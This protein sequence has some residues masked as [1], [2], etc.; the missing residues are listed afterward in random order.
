VTPASG[1]AEHWVSDGQKLKSAWRKRMVFSITVASE[2]SS[3]KAL[4][5]VSGPKPQFKA[6]GESRSENL[7]VG[8]S[9][10]K[11]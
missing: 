5:T 1:A 8:V 4:A 10:V 11:S 6:G 7:I 9:N 3:A 2:L